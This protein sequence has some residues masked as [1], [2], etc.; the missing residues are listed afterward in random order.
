[1][2]QVKNPRHFEVIETN[3]Q[4]GIITRRVIEQPSAEFDAIIADVLDDSNPYVAGSFVDNDVPLGM[5]GRGKEFHFRLKRSKYDTKIISYE[6]RNES[7]GDDDE[8]IVQRFI[9]FKDFIADGFTISVRHTENDGDL[10]EVDLQ[11][12]KFAPT[13]NKEV[14]RIRWVLRAIQKFNNELL[15]EVA[16]Q[17]DAD[18]DA[19]EDEY[20]A[21]MEQEQDPESASPTEDKPAE[22]QKPAAKFDQSTITKTER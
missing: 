22:P 16:D 13:D 12:S 20:E 7:H 8:V 9:D 11:K 3:P 10:L 14:N 21:E 18:E 2:E 1:M 5:R 6:L 15:T 19:L 4:T 17:E